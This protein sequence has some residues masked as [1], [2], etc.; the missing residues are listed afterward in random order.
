[1]VL[2]FNGST[3]ECFKQ[4]SDV[5]GQPRGQPGDPVVPAARFHQLSEAGFTVLTV[6]FRQLRTCDPQLQCSAADR[7]RQKLSSRPMKTFEGASCGYP[8][9]GG[10]AAYGLGIMNCAGPDAFVD[11]RADRLYPRD[12]V[13]AHPAAIL[14]TPRVSWAARRSTWPA[15]RGHS[16]ITCFSLLRNLHAPCL[17]GIEPK[18]V[19]AECLL[20][21]TRRNTST[22]RKSSRTGFSASLDIAPVRPLGVM[23][24]PMKGATIRQRQNSGSTVDATWAD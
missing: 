18:M 12:A 10:I 19:C 7:Q 14:S 13:S 6:C 22:R 17:P 8:S 15:H 24:G 20:D 5:S 9:T 3:A 1:M 21:Q 4:G 16:P 23:K 11:W 2:F